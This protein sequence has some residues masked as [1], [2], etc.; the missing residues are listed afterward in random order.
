MTKKQT[1]LYWLI[2]AVIWS[3]WLFLI[4]IDGL[5]MGWSWLPW[6]GIGL[7]FAWQMDSWFR[8]DKLFRM[9]LL[10]LPYLV[11]ADLVQNINY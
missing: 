2:R 7:L 1:A 3:I 11:L 5:S 6:V 4:A 9:S 10:I 8:E